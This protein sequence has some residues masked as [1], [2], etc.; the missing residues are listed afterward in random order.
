MECFNDEN[1]NLPAAKDFSNLKIEC[2]NC[3]GLCCVALYFSA[4]EG[5]PTDKVAGKP[6]VN[7]K[8]DFK[9]KVHNNLRDKGL[10]GC[11]AYDCFGAGQ[12]VAQVTYNGLDWNR[13]KENTKEMFEVFL[14]MRQLHEMLW[15]LSEAYTL[16]NNRPL[17]SDIMEVIIETEEFTKLSA[18]LLLALDIEAHR[19]KVNE[20]L[21]QTSDF[22]RA[23][24]FSGSA[25]A[26]KTK[27]KLLKRLDLFGADLRKTN[28]IGADLRG[29]LLI[30]ANL[31]GNDLSGADLIGSDMR[32]ANI[33]GAD[34]SKS[35][36]LTQA[37]INSAK[38]DS[39]TKL[40]KSLKHPSYWQK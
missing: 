30:A 32:D 35:I 7:L 22:I 21:K 2:E 12:K 31:S 5:F 11:T 24:A 23:K 27:K 36:F 15:Y 25:T 26:S 19:V 6:C 16:Q 1:Q 4:S 28:L 18:E 33:M 14:I 38:G 3:F 40:P 29:A 39:R 17:Q 34:L 10:K 13:N 37:Q 8:S 20:I 9:C